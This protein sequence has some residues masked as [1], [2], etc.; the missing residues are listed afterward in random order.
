M[1][2]QG[3]H[4]LLV[5]RGQFL[6]E[7][8]TVDRL[9]EQLGDF[10]ARVVDRL[11]QLNRSAIVRRRIVQQCAATAINLDLEGDAELSAITED[12]LMMTGK[13]RRA[14]IPVQALIEVANLARAVSHV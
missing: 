10:T 4:P 5:V 9:A 7:R 8:A 12:G 3:E 2:R 11:A 14:C 13:P 1:P 6:V